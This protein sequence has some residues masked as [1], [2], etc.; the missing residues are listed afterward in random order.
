MS[1]LGHIVWYVFLNV[2]EDRCGSTF[3][4]HWMIKT[5]YPDRKLAT[6]QLDYMV[7]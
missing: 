1:G 4:D 6:H 5:I 7:P 2:Y 3:T